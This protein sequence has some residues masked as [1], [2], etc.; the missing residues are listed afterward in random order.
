[1]VVPALD[2]GVVLVASNVV[3]V[4]ITE[5]SVTVDSDE[6]PPD[7]LDEHAEPAT[8]NTTKSAAKAIAAR[9]R[10]S[11]RIGNGPGSQLIRR[12][13]RLRARPGPDA[14][15]RSPSRPGVPRVSAQELGIALMRV[16]VASAR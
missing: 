6:S 16:R 5:P 8:T 2:D 4:P 15:C 9:G 12:R 11:P 14:H 7:P 1:M 3:V 13:V 10:R